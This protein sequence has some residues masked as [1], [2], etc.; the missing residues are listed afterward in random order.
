MTISV[1]EKKMMN[2]DINGPLPL[3]VK[4]SEDINEDIEFQCNGNIFYDFYYTTTGIDVGDENPL[5]KIPA[6]TKAGT[7]IKFNCI[8]YDSI[9]NEIITL[10]IAETFYKSEYHQN[11]P[12]E[13]IK[14]KV[15]K[16][17]DKIEFVPKFVVNLS[18][19]TS[20]NLEKKD[21][22]YL[23]ITLMED[24]INENEIMDGTFF[25]NK[26]NG[27][28]KVNLI[29]CTKIPKNTKKGNLK[30][31]CLVDEE[32]KNGNFTLKL[33]EGKKIGDIEP[34]VSGYIVFSQ[35]GPNNEDFPTEIEEEIQSSLPSDKGLS[36]KENKAKNNIKLKPI[37][38]LVLL[39][40]L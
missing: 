2:L 9:Y 19:T 25:L 16:N 5:P 35:D 12:M 39:S 10:T 21:K 27:E 37:I 26:E 11:N 40:L 24:I 31:T 34:K 1:G 15:D 30:I 7:E 20:K 8:I 23:D 18:F 29:S 14:W 17:N 28:T 3:I 32:V 36:N 38:I 4:P 6:G 13:N 22:I 33:N